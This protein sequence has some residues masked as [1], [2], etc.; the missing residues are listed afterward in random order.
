VVVE[1][2]TDRSFAFDVSY[3]GL[4]VARWRYSIG[5]VADGLM[6]VEEWWDRRGWLMT[7]LSTRGTGVADRRAHNEAGMEAT[8]AALRAEMESPT[9]G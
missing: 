1:S 7:S 4:A 8:L 3:L 2:V 9:T 5:E 6:V